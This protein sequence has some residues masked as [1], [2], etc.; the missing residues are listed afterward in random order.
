M[1]R[2]WK[3]ILMENL[4]SGDL[5]EFIKTDVEIEKKLYGAE[6]VQNDPARQT[7]TLNFESLSKY[8]HE[9]HWLDIEKFWLIDSNTKNNLELTK[10]YVERI[11]LKDIESYIG[12]RNKRKTMKSCNMYKNKKTKRN[13]KRKRR[14]KASSSESSSQSEE[15]VNKS[16][17]I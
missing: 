4:K 6:V 16:N 10:G 15:S 2:K 7:L 9:I 12:N 3:G 1:S 14:F 13:M 11:E 8:Y 5:I 17:L